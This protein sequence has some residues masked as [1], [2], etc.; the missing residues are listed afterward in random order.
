MAVHDG[1][2]I[3]VDEARRRLADVS[4][5]LG[6]ER[7]PLAAALYRTV[8]ETV[9]ADS[10]LPPFDRAAMDGYALASADTRSAPGWLPVAGMTQA[11][12]VP[13]PLMPGTARRIFTG[14]PIPA[15]AD[16]VLEQEA[17][18]DDGGGRVHISRA[19]ASGRNI[20]AR[21]HEVPMGQVVL[22]RGSRMGSH[23][24]GLLA[25]TGR[26]DVTVFRSVTVAV[27][28]VGS[29]L[30][31]PGGPLAP[32]HIYPVHRVFIPSAVA[33]WGGMTVMT[34]TVPDD[35]DAI[36]DALL[37]ATE[38][39]QVVFTT[40]GTSVGLFDF[41]PEVLTQVG[42][43][44]FWRVAMHPGKAVAA[45][46]R[47]DRLIVSLSGN[48]GAAYTSFMALVA[49]WWAAQHQ[50]TLCERWVSGPLSEAYPKPTR[51]S[52]YLRVRFNGAGWTWK[53]LPQGAD[54]LTAYA[55]A[56]GFAVI[57]AG[58]ERL[59]AGDLVNVWLPSGMG[60]RWPRWD[61]R[62]VAVE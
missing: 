25:A 5:P 37:R 57:P 19:V 9:Y 35:R 2:L 7:V 47:G 56:D 50:G 22:T 33:E 38:T 23:S 27:V 55:E 44:L 53:A 15:G 43:L 48:P 54:V 26:Q 40:G 59:A 17:V 3:E 24:L 41:L 16:T 29:E 34:V 21:G 36:A 45:A 31:E 62:S 46:R 10:A 6:V 28:E 42:T 1:K 13:G 49:P 4:V 11:G 8:A 52:R 58:T 39:A 51:E 30:G 60:G 12:D 14:A 32:A 61:G 20:M 18:L